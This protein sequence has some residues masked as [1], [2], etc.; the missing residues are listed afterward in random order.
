MKEIIRQYDVE[1]GQGDRLQVIEY[2]LE[3]TLK[4]GIS[5]ANFVSMKRNSTFKDPE[6]K[7]ALSN[8]E[9]VIMIDDNTFQTQ[10][11]P[12]RRFYIRR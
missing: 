3:V 7:Y 12:V 1:D 11:E 9:R 5:T 10:D 2:K 6:S 8:G 4:E